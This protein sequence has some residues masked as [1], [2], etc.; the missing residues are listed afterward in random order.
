MSF[1]PSLPDMLALALSAVVVLIALCLS[2][3][4]WQLE[5]LVRYE[6]TDKG[7]MVIIATFTKQARHWAEAT[8]SLFTMAT[9]S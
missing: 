1:N 4:P 3:R 6:K 2:V 9:S 7:V 8:R 5:K